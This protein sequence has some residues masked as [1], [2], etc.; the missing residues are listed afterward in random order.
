M[1]GNKHVSRDINL[2]LD[3][4]KTKHT[5]KSQKKE[6][7]SWHLLDLDD[8]SLVVLQGAAAPHNTTSKKKKKIKNYFPF[9]YLRRESINST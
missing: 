8:V 2:G 4:A 7:P 1:L 6:P 9:V 3:G 5:R